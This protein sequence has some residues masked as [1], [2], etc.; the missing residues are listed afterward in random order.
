LWTIFLVRLIAWASG[1]AS[2]YTLGNFVIA[3]MV[4]VFQLL[5]GR[6]SLPRETCRSNSSLDQATSQ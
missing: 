5:S 4:P 3:L 1:L 6:R 2:G